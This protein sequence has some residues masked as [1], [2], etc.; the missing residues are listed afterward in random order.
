M[1]RKFK[2]WETV[3][4]ALIDAGFTGPFIVSDITAMIFTTGLCTIL[5]TVVEFLVGTPNWPEMV[6]AWL[7]VYLFIAFPITM[8]A[9][10]YWYEMAKRYPDQMEKTDE[11]VDDIL[12][13]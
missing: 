8:M 2:K 4:G 5:G 3:V 10:E 13:F 1:I 12:K 7:V 9:W 11:V 6:L